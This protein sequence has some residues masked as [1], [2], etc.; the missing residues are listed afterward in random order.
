M[1]RPPLV[2]GLVL[3]LLLAGCATPGDDGTG[4]DAPAA[5]AGYALD[6]SIA[7]GMG[8]ASW[9]E[10]CLALA[11]PNDSPSKTEIDLAVNPTN[12]DN[13]VVSS[14]DMDPRASE[15][16]WAV[17]QV[18]KDGGRTWKTVILGGEKS[19]RAPGDPLWGWECITDPIMAFDAEGTLYYSLQAYD[20]TVEFSEVP[21]PLGTGVIF[22]VGSSILMA[23]S[24]DGGET[25]DPPI[26]LHAGEGSVIFHDYMR[27]AV[28]PATGS[29]YTIWNQFNT[30]PTPRQAP[31]A[32]APTTQ[33][34]PVLVASRDGGD[35]A[36]PPTYVPIPETATTGG[37]AMRGLAVHTDGTVYVLLQAEAAGQGRQWLTV[38]TDDARTF[39]APREIG[40]YVEVPRMMKNYT[41]RSGTMSELAVDASGGP[42]DGC[43]YLS[44]ADYATGD[45]DVYS[46]ASCDKGETWSDPTLV[47]LDAFQPGDQW[48]QRPWV[49]TEGGY[50]LVYVSA[51][52]DTGTPMNVTWALS[53]DGG[54]TF[55]NQHLTSTPFDPTLGLHQDGGSFIGDYN[56]IGGAGEVVYMGFAT[57]VT[58]RAEVGVARVRSSG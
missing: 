30:V 18:S 56:G 27:M 48:M 33:V 6:C 49:D 55:Q 37:V 36:D 4:E 29:V 35:T 47:N 15:C 13:V 34:V 9:R 22:A 45:A 26:T 51:T 41:Y 31:G 12:P 32:P 40:R 28:N 42:R 7:P 1:P 53:T 58:G 2:F 5:V 54:I 52:G 17:P 57:T 8:N 39:S 44:Y 24:R 50:H 43:L 14:K 19:Q 21:D 38:S 3:M 11:S 20:H 25:F 16:V 23:R 10:P 46:R